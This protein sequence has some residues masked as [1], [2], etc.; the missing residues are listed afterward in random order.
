MNS[1]NV[2]FDSDGCTLA[3][4][5][6]QAAQPVAAA[7]LIPGS[8]RTDR[9]S[10]VKLPLGMKLRGAITRA[11]AEALGTVNVSSLRYDKRG[12]GA[13]GGDYYPVGMATRLIDAQAA[14]GWLAERNPGLPLLVVGHSEGT[15]YAAQL[16]G[17]HRGV[18][19]IVLISGSVRPGGDVLAWQTAA[20][21]RQ[22]AAPR[23]R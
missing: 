18:A 15:Y 23:R 1:E 17:E 19:G 6:A 4:T 21:R 3:G 13:S 2:T 11:V 20:A 9:D 16:A 5:Y 12:V 14:L 8:G 10:D 7:L 22:A